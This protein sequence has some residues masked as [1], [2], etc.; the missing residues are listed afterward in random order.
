[1]TTISFKGGREIEAAFRALGNAPAARRSGQRAVVKAL[2]PIKETARRMAPDDPSTGAGKFLKE[3]IKTGPR[4]SRDKD[5]VWAAV[6]IDK[7]VD[8]PK[9][10]ARK[11]GKGSYRDPG[12]AGVA[13]MQEFGTEKMAANPYL[14]PAW[15]QGRGEL[16]EFLGRAVWADI[17]ATAKRIAR[18]Q[19]KLKG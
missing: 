19:A 3:A 2:E 17:E 14:G 4:K 18:K 8:P 16:P 13:V 6:G 1:M 10:V 9:D 15:E 5:R 11:N 12:V 7:S